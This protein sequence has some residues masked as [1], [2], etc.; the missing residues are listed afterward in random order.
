V[1]VAAPQIPV[2]SARRV[3]SVRMLL[4]MTAFPDGGSTIAC[5]P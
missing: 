4:L 2:T 5:A 1:S 3:G